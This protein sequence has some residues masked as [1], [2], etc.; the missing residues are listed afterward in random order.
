MN[1]K[2]LISQIVGE[3]PE[4]ERY[5]DKVHF[6]PFPSN[7]V[8]GGY[9]IPLGRIFLFGKYEENTLIFSI[10]REMEIMSLRDR[11]GIWRVIYNLFFNRHEIERT[12]TRKAISL[13]KK[14]GRDDYLRWL[15][16][17]ARNYK[18]SL[19]PFEKLI[20]KTNYENALDER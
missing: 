7:K 11:E 13:L 2:K 6:F 18:K 3:N 20:Y 9:V 14:M 19:N 17:I 1:L 4:F 8:F 12:A 10:I 5:S 16:E 15:K